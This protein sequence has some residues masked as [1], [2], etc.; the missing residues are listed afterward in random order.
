VKLSAPHLTL[1]GNEGLRGCSSLTELNCQNLKSVGTF[2]LAGCNS[3][4]MLDLPNL[5]LIEY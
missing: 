4:K 3:I 1:I 2:G 5:I